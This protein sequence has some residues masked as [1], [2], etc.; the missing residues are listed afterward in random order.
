MRTFTDGLSALALSLAVPLALSLAAASCGDV[1]AE[2][3]AGLTLSAASHDFGD[4]EVGPPSAP[5]LLTVTNGG[6]RTSGK[7]SA[8][9]SSLTG[10]FLMDPDQCSGELLAPGGSCQIRIVMQSGT[11]GPAQV[12]LTVSATGGDSVSSTLTG[13]AF[14]RQIF[15]I[16]DTA[17]DFGPVTVGTAGP[18]QN[19][20]LENRGTVATGTLAVLVSGD[21]SDFPVASDQ[22]SGQR[23]P[24][25]GSCTVSYRFS[26]LAGGSR[27]AYLFITGATHESAEGDL[28]GVGL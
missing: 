14:L 27:Q 10:Q 25:Q 9:F 19:F 16:P 11:W 4:V 12:V 21:A 1:P 8:R 18:T 5:F 24:P 20:V 28:S 6:R 22:C 26:P 23:L 15:L 2:P 17:I 13:T 3:D 7:L